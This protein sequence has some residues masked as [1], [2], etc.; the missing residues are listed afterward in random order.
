MG[1]AQGH[2]DRVVRELID[3]AQ[4]VALAV[5][6]RARVQG[7]D[8]VPLIAGVGDDRAA[9]VV[10]RADGPHVDRPGQALAGQGGVGGLID[11]DAGHHLRG[12]LVEL[13]AA[14]VAGRDHLAPVQQGGGEVRTQA[15]DRD[16]LAA[17]VQ[18]LHRHAGQ[19]GQ[20]FGDRHVRQLADV[21]GRDDL[22]DRGVVGLGR[23]RGLDRAADASHDDFV[24]LGRLLVARGRAL[25]L[26]H[27]AQRQGEDDA[28]RA[29]GHEARAPGEARIHL[30]LP[31]VVVPLR[32]RSRKSMQ[33]YDRLASR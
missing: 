6:G 22:D 32:G 31:M 9:A 21:L 14:V 7:A 11:D 26:G 28:E 13:D 16:Q 19:A 33:T 2:A 10:Q 23:N 30:I 25:R 15:A 5:V 27:A 24:D 18:P 17:T 8:V 1:V 20:G 3:I 4:G 29:A 12:E